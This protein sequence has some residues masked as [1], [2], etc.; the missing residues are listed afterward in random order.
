MSIDEKKNAKIKSNLICG[1]I[2]GMAST[3]IGMPFDQVK[4]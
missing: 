4:I 1:T 2:A 3:V